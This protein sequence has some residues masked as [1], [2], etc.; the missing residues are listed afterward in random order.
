MLPSTRYRTAGIKLCCPPRGTGQR[1]SKYVAFHAVQDS[2]NQIML[3]STQY[4]TAGIKLCCPPRGTGQRESNYIAL[5]MVQD[6]RN[7]IHQRDV[8]IQ[9]ITCLFFLLFQFFSK[10]KYGNAY[11]K[12]PKCITFVINNNSTVEYKRYTYCSFPFGN[13]Y[14][15]EG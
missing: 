8:K 10:T 11:F 12:V 4:R 9:S 14:N 13:K 15:T 3:P 2:G 7:Q 5:H 1:E 6:S